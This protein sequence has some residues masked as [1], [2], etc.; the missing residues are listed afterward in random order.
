[1]LFGYAADE[2][3]LATDAQ[4]VQ[5]IVNCIDLI[6]AAESFEVCRH[7]RIVD[8]PAGGCQRRRSP[9]VNQ[10]KRADRKNQDEGTDEKAEIKMQIAGDQVKAFAHVCLIH[11]EYS[12]RTGLDRAQKRSQAWGQAS[13]GSRGGTILRRCPAPKSFLKTMDPFSSRATSRFWIRPARR[14]GSRAAP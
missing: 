6:A 7:G 10:E 5:Y 1:M 2:S 9:R 3:G 11:R 13:G 4:A 14:S 8:R 12:C